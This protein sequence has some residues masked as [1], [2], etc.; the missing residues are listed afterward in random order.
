MSIRV[1]SIQPKQKAAR[2]QVYSGVFG[3]KKLKSKTGLTVARAAALRIAWP[4]LFSVVSD[5]HPP[6]GCGDK[7][8]QAQERLAVITL[9]VP[10]HTHRVPCDHPGGSVGFPAACRRHAAVTVQSRMGAINYHIKSSQAAR[11]GAFWTYGVCNAD[12][13]TLE[14][15]VM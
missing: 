3:F 11:A 6:S 14:R 2:R 8:I 1:I 5:A 15:V 13:S 9:A 12:K 10:N 4:V 7:H